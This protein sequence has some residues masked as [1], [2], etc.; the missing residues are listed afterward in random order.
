MVRRAEYLNTWMLTALKIAADNG[1]KLAVFS[2]PF[3]SPPYKAWSHL[4]P[5]LK[6]A[7]ELGG[8]LSLHSYTEDGPLLQR[9]ADGTFNQFTLD[10]GL[11]HRRIYASLPPEARLP[12]LYSECSP[13]NGYGMGLSG[14][15]WVNV[16]GEYDTELFKDDY[17]IGLDA[18][19]LGGDE[20]NLVSVLDRYADYISAHPT[21]GNPGK[22]AS[23]ADGMMVTDSFGSIIDEA[24]NQWTLG[25]EMVH[26]RA[27]LKNGQLFADGQGT[28]LLYFNR[29]IFAQND[30]NEW[31]VVSG[32]GWQAAAGDPRP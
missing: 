2:F 22:S 5:A 27:V 15:K 13:N 24:G 12:L 8:I 7:K 9:N 3:G 26:G 6:R 10:R 14:Q 20:S 11:R 25:S 17:I 21:P 28:L 16:M 29:Q 18:F 30:L 1:F 23:S 31:W 19:Q 4:V 32:D